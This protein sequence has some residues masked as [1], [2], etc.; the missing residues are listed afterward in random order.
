MMLFSTQ[1]SSPVTCSKSCWKSTIYLLFAS[2]VT[3]LGYYFWK[4]SAMN[5]R[6]KVAQLIGNFLGYFEKYLF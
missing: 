3:N 5:L 1:N 4:V 6:T 2:S